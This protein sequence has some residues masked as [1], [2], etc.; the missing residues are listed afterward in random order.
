M[1]FRWI[2]QSSKYK[3]VFVFYTQAAQLYLES[4]QYKEFPIKVIIENQKISTM[5]TIKHSSAVTTRNPLQTVELQC[6]LKELHTIADPASFQRWR[7]SFLQ[8]LEAMLDTDG[9][10]KARE[11]DSVVLK[12]LPTLDRTINNVRSCVRN[13]HISV[14]K[15]MGVKG[16]TAVNKLKEGCIDMEKR[17]QVLVPGSSAEAEAVGY[18]K[19]QLGAVLVKDGFKIYVYLVRQEAILK[20]LK[21]SV[22]EKVGVDRQIIDSLSYYL[23]QIRSLCDVMADL[24]L[25]EVMVKTRELAGDKLFVSRTKSIIRDEKRELTP[26][27]GKNNAEDASTSPSTVVDLLPIIDHAIDDEECFANLPILGTPQQEDPAEKPSEATTAPIKRQA[28]PQYAQKAQLKV[29]PL[30]SEQLKVVPL[31]QNENDKNRVAPQDPPQ[32][33]SPAQAGAP[34][35]NSKNQPCPL[36]EEVSLAERQRRVLSEHEKLSHLE[37]SESETRRNL[38]SEVAKKEEEDARKAIMAKRAKRKSKKTPKAQESAAKACSSEK[39]QLQVITA[40]K[41]TEERD[42]QAA[43]AK[44][45]EDQQ[46]QVAAKAKEEQKKDAAAAKAKEEQQKQNAAAA[47]AKEEQQKEAAAKAQEEQQKE[48][49]AVKAKEEQQKQAAAKANEEQQKQAEA[50]AKEKA[51]P[52]PANNAPQ[53]KSE[54][55]EPKSTVQPA[56][57]LEEEDKPKSAAK[58]EP[59]KNDKGEG[60]DNDF[61]IFFDPKTQAMGKLDKRRCIELGII[62]VSSQCGTDSI[63]ENLE[64]EA[65]LPL[66]RMIAKSMKRVLGNR[67]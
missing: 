65:K 43:A 51:K 34:N 41:A 36:D 31:P 58:A 50:A 6:M 28:K 56:K 14:D 25:F 53:T 3:T 67:K 18:N 63:K 42:K 24:E 9:I 40:R 29:E 57:P 20:E 39:E 23:R 52:K 4:F 15:K 38:A 49:K 2:Q 61:L 1:T 54:D 59:D 10:E 8:S 47:K 32:K 33:D 44:A 48:A 21:V 45:K 27:P 26:P 46:E 64:D 62:T 30:A 60:D 37:Q 12:K 35:E 19:F 11:A 13:G 17:L 7:S 16:Q 22:L 5:T 66:M 55:A